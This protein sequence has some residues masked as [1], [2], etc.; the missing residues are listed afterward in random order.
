MKERMQII[1]QYLQENGEAKLVDLEK[2]FP[3]ISSMT[4]RR[5]LK[6]LEEF[7]DVVLTKGGAKSISHLSRIK[8]ELYSKRLVEN[9]SE[10]N[11]IAK[12]ALEFLEEGRSIFLDSGTTIMYLAQ[13]LEK[14]K[15]FITTSAPNIALECVKNP[16]ATI[17][18]VGGELSRD[19]LSLSGINALDFL[20]NI[21]I[22]TAFIATSGFT[23]KNGFTCGN[24]QE[25]EIKKKV[26][27]K[28]SKVI[29][30]MDSSKFGKSMPFT[31]ATLDDVHH[32]ITDD[33][34][35]SEAKNKI[36]LKKQ[37]ILM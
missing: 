27:A 31:F 34:I 2:L 1:K 36:N 7:G 15:L 20:N 19:N 12:K 5:D 32:L 3:N 14:Q 9:T 37:N 23:I 18:L 16:N 21:N 33:N 26:I 6:R 13:L 28:A 30:L 35:T 8:E 11:L 24:Y 25:A 29:V 17:N 10:K 22:D 4:L